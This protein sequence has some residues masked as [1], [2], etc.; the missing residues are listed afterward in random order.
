MIKGAIRRSNIRRLL[1]R[2]S[3]V[4]CFAG[5]TASWNVFAGPIVD[6]REWY[7]PIDVLGYSWSQFDA[8][9]ATGTCSGLI[10]GAGPD[11]TGWTWASIYDVG[12]L[13]EALTPHPGGIDN[14][15]SNLPESVLWAFDFFRLFTI[16]NRIFT[17]VE[18][19]GVLGVTSTLAPSGGAY[20]GSVSLQ[21][22]FGG[23]E[24]QVATS[25]TVSVNETWAGGGWLYRSP[26]VPA[27]ATVA[28]LGMALAALGFSR[29][30]RP[31]D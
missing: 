13:F 24:G 9:C 29:K 21:V 19:S 2:F 17:P 26:K 16:T 18:A 15:E 31:R 7:Q 28:L 14:Y 4:L 1:A 22:G 25:D 23:F 20:Y 6:G 10:G 12:E 5:W 11:L 8:I 30:S 3:V 27:P